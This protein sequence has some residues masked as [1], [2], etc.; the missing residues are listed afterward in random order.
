MGDNI[1]NTL[2]G[3]AERLVELNDKK[4]VLEEELKGLNKEIMELRDQTIPTIMEDSEVSKIK[5]P[6]I[7]TLFTSTETQA[8]IKAEDKEKVYNWL[9][10]NGHKDLIDEYVFP[11]RLKAWAKEQLNTGQHLPDELKV[12]Q[13]QSARVRKE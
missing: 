7:G 11:M 3:L 5:F 4:K 2:R 1:S 8:S 10:E 12:Y 13:Y 6:G 9:R